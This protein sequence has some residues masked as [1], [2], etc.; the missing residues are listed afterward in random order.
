MAAQPHASDDTASMEITEQ[1]STYRVFDGLV[2]W[3]SLG[4]A[5]LLLF[6]TLLF[7]TRVG[8]FGALVPTGVMVIAGVVALRKPP[9]SLD[10]S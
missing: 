10:K 3:G 8:F 7:C 2:R 1:R 4:V 9:T 6:L 5:A